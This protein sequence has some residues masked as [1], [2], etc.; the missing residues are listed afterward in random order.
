MEKI[1]RIESKKAKELYPTASPEMKQIFEH[2][3]GKEFFIEK[4]TDR[5]QNFSDIALLSHA[6]CISIYETRV[7]QKEEKAVL[8]LGKLLRIANAYNEGWT[9]NWGDHTEYKWFPY[10]YKSDGSWLVGCDG[11]SGSLAYPSGVCFKSKELAEDA[12]LKFRSI[13]D[14]YYMI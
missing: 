4:I 11:W 7:T 14:D 9:P 3:F 8:A 12:L 5:I 2:T 6:P 1:L 10:Y 13:F